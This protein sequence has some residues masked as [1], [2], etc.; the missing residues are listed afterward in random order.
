MQTEP[1]LHYYSKNSSTPNCNVLSR[2][3]Y[4]DVTSANL[5]ID[6][7]CKSGCPETMYGELH[8]SIMGAK[9]QDHSG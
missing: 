6:N 1:F 4:N 7:T 8:V 3:E 2:K 9:F 5:Q